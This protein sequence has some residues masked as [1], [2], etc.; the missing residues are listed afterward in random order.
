MRIYAT[1]TA[2]A[3][4]AALGVAAPVAAHAQDAIIGTIEDFGFNFCPRG[5]APTNGALL[6]IS[7][8]TALFSLLGTRYGGDG[9][10]TFALPNISPAR[11][12][13]P[14]SAPTGG[15]ARIYQDCNMGG[16]SVPLGL[17][18]YRQG[19]LPAPYSDNNV[20]A[21][22]ASP[23]WEVTLHDGPNL[24]GDSVTITGEDRCLV[25]RNFNDRTSSISVRKLPPQPALVGDA[26]A[27]TCIAV[28]GIY[29]A[30]N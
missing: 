19:D 20:S 9:R 17:G 1:L 18:E 12:S 7:K 27:I 13:A 11:S 26:P 29:P 3:T 8:N 15:E 25:G 5:W 23:G 16:W 14:A 21:V 2:I 30:R 10:K 28:L 4:A 6:D 24:N 22:T